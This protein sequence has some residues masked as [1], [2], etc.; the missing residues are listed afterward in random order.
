MNKIKNPILKFILLL[1]GGAIVGAAAS[2]SLHALD[3]FVDIG[4]LAS[5]LSSIII[6]NLLTIQLSIWLPSIAI[7]LVCFIK[8]YKISERK[9]LS[10]DEEDLADKFLSLSLCL[11][12]LSIIFMFTIFSI[13]ITS[14]IEPLSMLISAFLF[15]IGLCVSSIFEIASI[16]LMQKLHPEK[17]GD[18]LSP[19][20][21]KD[22]LASCDEGEKMLIYVAG[23]KTAMFMKKMFI[24]IFVVLIIAGLF[25]DT[26]I[27]PYL[28]LGILWGGFTASYHIYGYRLEK[29]MIKY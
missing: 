14:P 27:L 28:L 23:F 11:S 6:S 13:F 9:T 20:F 17:G 24:C 18:P 16:K 7:I 19:K 10:E 4:T 5:Y 15:L 3:H 2:F 21:E 26:G 22:L 8:A 25:I 12:T 1:L 29:G